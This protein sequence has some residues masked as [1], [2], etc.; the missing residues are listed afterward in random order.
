MPVSSR[1]IELFCLNCEK[2]YRKTERSI[3]KPENRVEQRTNPVN[4]GEEGGATTQLSI[5]QESHVDW[6]VAVFIGVTF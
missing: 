6:L 4:W 2:S 1:T 5:I 3:L